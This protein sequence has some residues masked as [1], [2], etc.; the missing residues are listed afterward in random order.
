MTNLEKATFVL[1]AR[2]ETPSEE[3]GGKIH[4]DVSEY[5]S[6][7]IHDDEVA[8]L[9]EEFD[10]YVIETMHEHKSL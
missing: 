4:I 7:A 10:K 9:A 8:Y 1:E 6:V 2:Y 3:I 5:L